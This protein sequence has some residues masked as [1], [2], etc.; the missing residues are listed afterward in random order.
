MSMMKH[1]I[2][3]IIFFTVVGCAFGQKRIPYQTVNL[4]DSVLLSV[5]EFLSQKENIPITGAILTFNLIDKKNYKYKD[6]IYSFRL[7]GPHFHRNI[8]IVNDKHIYIF[9]GYYTDE[10]IPE[11]YQYIKQNKLSSKIKIDYLKAISLFLEQ[12]Y[13]SENG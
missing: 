3:I 4:P 2:L 10:L 1:N 12:E 5:R 9:K 8:F 13:I 7:L 6:G 11:F